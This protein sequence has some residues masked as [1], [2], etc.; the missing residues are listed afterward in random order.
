MNRCV[1]CNSE[2]EWYGSQSYTTFCS[3]ECEDEYNQLMAEMDDKLNQAD[4]EE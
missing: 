1:V 3:Q 2:A 4:E